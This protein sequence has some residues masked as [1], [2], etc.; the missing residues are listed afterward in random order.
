MWWMRGLK[1]ITSAEQVWSPTGRPI[2]GD[3]M[4]L[5]PSNPGAFANHLLD[6]LEGEDWI[7]RGHME[8]VGGN[9]SGAHDLCVLG[10]R[11]R[12]SSLRT[13]TADRG[14][15]SGVADRKTTQAC[16]NKRHG[17]YNQAN[18]KEHAYRSMRGK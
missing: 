6:I 16:T 7:R 18:H 13:E 4:S 1:V 5:N 3:G 15:C 17:G 11:S 12:L 8:M 10:D 9:G 2:E 14:S